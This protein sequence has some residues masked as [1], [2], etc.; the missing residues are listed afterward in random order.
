[1]QGPV[2]KGRTRRKDESLKHS[3]SI[4]YLNQGS[5]E[6]TGYPNGLPI[7]VL[8]W[9]AVKINSQT[10]VRFILLSWR[11]QLLLPNQSSRDL[12]SWKHSV[13]E[14]TQKLCS[15]YSYVNIVSEIELRR[16]YLLEDLFVLFWFFLAGV[17]KTAICCNKISSFNIFHFK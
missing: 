5:L 16:P 10:G 17:N 11:C 6:N 12:L 1:M 4:S 15:K 9:V 14:A 2:L 13:F 7:R 8:I 3:I